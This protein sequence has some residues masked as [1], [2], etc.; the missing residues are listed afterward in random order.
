[1][2]CCTATGHVQVSSRKNSLANFS[3]GYKTDGEGESRSPL[4]RSAK[5]AWKA[6]KIVEVPCGMEINMYVSATRK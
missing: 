5:M 6:P 1:M 2:T 4:Q 3:S